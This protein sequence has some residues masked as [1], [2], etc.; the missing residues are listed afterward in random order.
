[1]EDLI[2]LLATVRT[3]K[4]SQ[5]YW[6][7]IYFLENFIFPCHEMSNRIHWEFVFLYNMYHVNL[8]KYVNTLKIYANT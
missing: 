5:I 3:L 8:Y 2:C 4:G 6:I 7:N 1:M